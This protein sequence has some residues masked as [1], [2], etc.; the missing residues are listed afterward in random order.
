MPDR[1]PAQNRPFGFAPMLVAQPRRLTSRKQ[2]FVLATVR[3]HRGHSSYSAVLGNFSP[4]YPATYPEMLAV[5][6]NQ[7]NPILFNILSQDHRYFRRMFISK[8]SSRSRPN[9]FFSALRLLCR[10]SRFL[11][12]SCLRQSAAGSPL[13]MHE[14]TTPSTNARVST[15]PN[16]ESEGASMGLGRKEI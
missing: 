1:Q 15:L 12:R 6:F 3:H 11:K 8:I 9:C 14:S 7:E 4:N 10:S 13:L 2:P 16:S 5:I